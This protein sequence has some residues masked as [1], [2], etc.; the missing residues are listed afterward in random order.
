MSSGGG[1]GGGGRKRKRKRRRRRRRQEIL[2][3]RRIKDTISS[4]DAALASEREHKGPSPSLSRIQTRRYQSGTQDSAG[5]VRRPELTQVGGNTKAAHGWES[6]KLRK[7]A[8][9]WASG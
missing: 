1:R 8:H 2:K 3:E 5:W 4:T 6:G 9:D 7:A